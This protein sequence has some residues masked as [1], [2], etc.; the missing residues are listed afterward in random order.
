ME[1][2]CWVRN[3]IRL[4]GDEFHSIH[5]DTS[6][7][8]QQPLERFFFY[9][10]LWR[11][12]CWTHLPRTHRARQPTATPTSSTSCPSSRPPW[13][14]SSSLRWAWGD[15]VTAPLPGGPEVT[16]TA[17]RRTTCGRLRRT[18]TCGCLFRKATCGRSHDHMRSPD[19]VVIS[20][21][22]HKDS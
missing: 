22:H 4:P 6:E 7:D 14:P 9:Q 19:K 16:P 17:C 1:E 10:H 11:V 12:L 20:P 8:V 21:K 18:T 3:Y 2:G 15:G 5:F 13:L